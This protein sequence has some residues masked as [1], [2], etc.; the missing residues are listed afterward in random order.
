MVKECG[1]G[2]IKKK[3]WGWYY[4]NNIVIY[5]WVFLNCM[6]FIYE[7]MFLCNINVYFFKCSLVNILIF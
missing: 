2:I 6:N 5:F 1:I 4:V 7:I 3:M